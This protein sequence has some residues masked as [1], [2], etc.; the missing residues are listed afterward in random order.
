MKKSGTKKKKEE[1]KSASCE[2]IIKI[3]RYKFCDQCGQLCPPNLVASPT[4]EHGYL[5]IDKCE[6]CGETK[7]LDNKKCYSIVI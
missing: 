4:A 1:K 3:E 5:L 6:Y 2:G 7:I